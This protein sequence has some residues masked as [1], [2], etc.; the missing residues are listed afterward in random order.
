MKNE[1]K[2]VEL[3]VEL[4]QRSDQHSD[5]MENQSKVIAEGFSK[6]TSILEKH[7]TMFEGILIKLDTLTEHEKRIGRLE[8]VV[9]KA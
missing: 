1:E 6:M 9:F 4:L 3:L 2:I 7:T 8:D 5:L